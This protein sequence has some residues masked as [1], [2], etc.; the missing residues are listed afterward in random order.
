M[1]LPAEFWEA[2]RRRLEAVL[3][4]ILT[5]ATVDAM[6]QASDKARFVF[7]PDL[8]NA[9]AALWARQYTDDLLRTLGTTN[10]RVVGQALDDWIS[11]PGGTIGDL[12]ASLTP[13][14]GPKRASVIATTEITRA[15]SSGEEMAY[16]SE[17]ITEWRWRTNRDELVCPICGRLNNQVRRIGQPFVSVRGQDVTKP[18]AHPNCRC[19]VT[20]VVDRSNITANNE[21]R[22]NLNLIDRRIRQIVAGSR[23]PSIEDAVMIQNR[24]ANAPFYR[25]EANVPS[26]LTGTQLPGGHVIGERD[27][28]IY[29]HL[30]K[31]IQQRQWPITTSPESYL[32]DLQTFA[33]RDDVKMLLYE[34]RGGNMVAFIGSSPYTEKGSEKNMIVVYSADHGMI[35]SGY[36]FSD[37]TNLNLGTNQR[38]LR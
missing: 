29:I 24:A 5:R 10:E 2:E 23:T 4:P 31:R 21:K 16:Q 33:K 9:Q 35:V 15:Y 28:S 32:N 11:K 17:G 8:A 13:Y 37:F 18:P 19:W 25:K 30:A 1:R 20:P 6:R 3:L 7:D 26:D 14:F 27:Q 12:Q 34:R 22:R 36:Q 38:W